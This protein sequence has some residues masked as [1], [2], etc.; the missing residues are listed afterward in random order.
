V[1]LGARAGNGG[2]RKLA[3]LDECVASAAVLGSLHPH[4]P[5]P[6]HRT[7]RRGQRFGDDDLRLRQVDAFVIRRASRPQPRPAPAVEDENGLP[8]RA[9]ARLFFVA[10]AK[11]TRVEAV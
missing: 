6:S 8:H 7:N 3:H 9:R 11:R 2:A 1:E 10:V 4:A 5:V